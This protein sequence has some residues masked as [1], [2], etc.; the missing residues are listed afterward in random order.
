MVL[1]WVCCLCCYKTEVWRFGFADFV[2]LSGFVWIFVLVLFSLIV[3]IWNVRC[4]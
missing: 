1:N 4:F 3:V 2:W